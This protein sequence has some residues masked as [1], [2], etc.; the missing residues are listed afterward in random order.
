[1]LRSREG[2]CWRLKA[3][4]PQKTDGATLDVGKA[5]LPGGGKGL[6]EELLGPLGVAGL[7]ASEEHSGPLELGAG[8]PRRGADALVSGGGDGE[9]ALRLAE[10]AERRGQH[11]QV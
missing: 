4:S 10:V 7:A 3:F 6:V 1:M 9:A 11:G 8:E 5:E 2:P